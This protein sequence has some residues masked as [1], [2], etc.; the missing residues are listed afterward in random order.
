[1]HKEVND[2][3]QKIEQVESRKESTGM[4]ATRVN[5]ALVVYVC[6][7]G[8][9][10]GAQMHYKPDDFHVLQLYYSACP[11]P[12]LFVLKLILTSWLWWQTRQ[13]N[14]LTAKLATKKTELRHQQV[15]SAPCATPKGVKKQMDEARIPTHHKLRDNGSTAEEL[16]DKLMENLTVCPECEKNNSSLFYEVKTSFVEA[17]A[18]TVRKQ[19][20]AKGLFDEDGM[21]VCKNLDVEPARSPSR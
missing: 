6:A 2:L 20:Q 5:W 15:L 4:W 19:R 3:S 21:E 10:F 1:M 8:L 16:M 18:N 17:G 13:W 9:M 14:S 12:V 11:M 7:V